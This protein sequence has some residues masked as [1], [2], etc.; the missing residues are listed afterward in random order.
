MID[1]ARSA[2]G[3][4]AAGNL[5]WAAGEHVT[6]SQ[7]ADTLLGAQVVRAVELDINRAWVAGYL[8]GHRDG[9]GPLAPVPVVAGQR[10]D[11]R[12]DV[13]LLEPRLLHGRHTMREGLGD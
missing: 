2:L 5:I 4:T 12:R 9:K 8:Y 7:I 1:P 13:G 6:V 3:I 10:G 11:P